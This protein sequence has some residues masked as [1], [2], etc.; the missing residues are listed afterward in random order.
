MKL[1]QTNVVPAAGCPM[2]WR[3]QTAGHP[4]KQQ[5][6]FQ[7]AGHPTKQKMW[8]QTGGASHEKFSRWVHNIFPVWG[9]RCGRCVDLGG[10]RGMRRRRGCDWVVIVVVVGVCVCVCV[11]VYTCLCVG[12]VSGF[13][14]VRVCVRACWC[15]GVLVRV[16]ARARACV[17]VCA[18][19]GVCSRLCASLEFVG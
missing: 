17:C 12:G 6:W 13:V 14:C 8:I 15:V 19:V 10:G 3:F 2:R 18:C 16:S 11:C 7:T 4:M 9:S 5:M 1:P